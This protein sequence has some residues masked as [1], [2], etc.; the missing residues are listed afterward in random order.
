MSTQFGQL[1][2]EYRQ[3]REL[4]QK[5]LA[6][7]AGYHPSYI[8]RLERGTRTPPRQYGTIQDLA[9]ALGLTQEDA[10]DG[11]STR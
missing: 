7:K 11:L 3:R 9:T 8:N 1:L 5:A 2:R 4:S 6:E 10:C